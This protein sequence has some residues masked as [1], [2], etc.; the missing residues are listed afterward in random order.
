MQRNKP[1]DLWVMRV[2]NLM[3][4]GTPDLHCKF[5]GYNT[6][7][8]WVELKVIE[9]PKRPNTRVV[10]KNTF[11]PGQIAW[12]KQYAL[13][14][15]SS[16]VILRDDTK[17]LFLV[18]NDQLE[19]LHTGRDEFYIRFSFEKDWASLWSEIYMSVSA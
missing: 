14:H 15:A 17:C 12:H 16:F 11:E 5:K 9:R 18:K 4:I 10:K 7:P 3:E 19:H 8:F 13:L 2:E 6:Q 1:R